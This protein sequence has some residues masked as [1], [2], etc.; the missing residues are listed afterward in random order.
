MSEV[1]IIGFMTGPVQMTGLMMW[2][3]FTIND[4]FGQPGQGFGLVAKGFQ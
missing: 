1:R 2:L 3:M 4:V